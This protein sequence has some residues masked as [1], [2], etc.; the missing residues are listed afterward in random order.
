VSPLAKPPL[1]AQVWAVVVLPL[2]AVPAQLARLEQQRVVQL[3]QV[4]PLRHPQAL[5]L[6]WLGQLR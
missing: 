2:E 1:W 6:G 5:V 3:V 4:G